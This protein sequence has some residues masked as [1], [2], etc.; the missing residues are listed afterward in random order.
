M[1]TNIQL[2]VMSGFLF[3][4]DQSAMNLVLKT[5]Y[6][7]RAVV[8]LINIF[9][10]LT[11]KEEWKVTYRHDLILD[12][13]YHQKINKY[14]KHLILIRLS[15]PTS[16]IKHLPKINRMIVVYLLYS[17]R[18]QVYNNK[19]RCPKV[20]PNIKILYILRCILQALHDWTK[21]PNVRHH[22]C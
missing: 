12:A 10:C 11:V 7:P 15:I 13:V 5:K 6:T 9:N 3:T 22:Y 2:G 1:N 17:C 20:A 16:S 4:T 8:R 19:S 18:E 21:P 14:N